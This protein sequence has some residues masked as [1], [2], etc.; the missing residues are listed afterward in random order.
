MTMASRRQIGRCDRHRGRGETEIDGK[1]SAGS[2]PEEFPSARTAPPYISNEDV[3]T[4]SVINIAS[5]KV[6]HIV[7]VGQEPREWPRRRMESASMSLRSR[8]RRIRHRCRRL[9]DSRA[10][11]SERAS[12]QRGFSAGTGVGFIPSESTG[13]LNVIDTVNL[14]V[15]KVITLP[16]ARGP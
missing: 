11:Q 1:I 14:N 12:A 2:D 6:E 4:A 13:E 5:G 8:R 3:K 16:P 7:S 9:H 10:F 15:L